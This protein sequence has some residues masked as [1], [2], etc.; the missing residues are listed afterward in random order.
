MHSGCVRITMLSSV[1]CGG[2][3]SVAVPQ[4]SW[5]LGTVLEIP[6]LLIPGIKWQ[7]IMAINHVGHFAVIS[8]LLYVSTPVE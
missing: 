2:F 4:I 7:Y 1:C 5:A 6:I 3:F 8:C